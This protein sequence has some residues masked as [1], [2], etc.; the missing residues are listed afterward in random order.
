MYAPP[1]FRN[2]D[3]FQIY[4]FID[5]NSFANVISNVGRE[6]WASHIPLM[7]SKDRTTLYGHVAKANQQ[8]K[9]FQE[10]REVL[11]I[12]NGPHA[13]ISSSWYD[14]ENVPTWNYIAAQVYGNA[15]VVEGEELITSL[16]DLTDKYEKQSAHPVSI[17]AM[18]PG[19][20]EKELRGLVGI[21][22]S[23]TRIE[24]S[25]KL[26]QNRDDKNYKSIVFHLSQRNQG[27]DAL[28]ADAMKKNR[29]S[30]K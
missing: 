20:F 23:V 22:I 21:A 6:L 30:E 28:V 9:H 3:L 2:E 13:Y 26:S 11:A 24:A 14:H 12:F 1:I 15:S 10:R 16:S 5:Q 4:D 18:S 7:F 29:K 25:Y 19:Y 8:W 17:S 27:A